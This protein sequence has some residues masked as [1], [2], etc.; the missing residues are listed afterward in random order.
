MNKLGDIAEITM[1]MAPP[2]SSYNDKGEGVPLVQGSLDMGLE[3]PTI[4]TWTREPVKM[5]PKGTILMA[6]RAPAGKVNW[7]DAEYSIGRGIAGISVDNEKADSRYVFHYLESHTEKIQDRSRRVATGALSYNDLTDLPLELPVKDSQV[8]A[9]PKLEALMRVRSN[10]EDMESVM[11]KIRRSIFLDMFG[12]P[13]TNT[14]GRDIVKL[15]E[16]AKFQRGSELPKDDWV[17]GDV[18]VCGAK[19][20]VGH[21][22]TPLVQGPCVITG[23]TGTIGEAYYMDGPLWPL[24]TVLYTKDLGDVDPIYLAQLIRELD[25]KRFV[26]STTVACIDRKTLE[27]L[28]VPVADL[29]EQEKYGTICRCLDANL[30]TMHQMYDEAQRMGMAVLNRGASS[31]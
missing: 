4:R 29:T 12:D 8:R 23:R 3:Y 16:L 19:Y 30:K 28:E 27:S 1:G 31:I 6:L 9:A 5:V 10:L 7:A 11:S 15:G 22:I 2:S 25:L 18:S 17:S 13:K 20:V 24:N 26:R 14:Q 21:C